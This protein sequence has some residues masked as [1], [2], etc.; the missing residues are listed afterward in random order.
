MEIYPNGRCCVFQPFDGGEFDRRFDDI[1]VPAIESAAMEPY[2]VYRDPGATIPIETLHQE[3]RSAVICVA[4]ITTRNPNVMYE[5][6]YAT[7]SGK[8]LV[9][10]SGPSAEKFP[11][12]IQ[13]HQVIRYSA[14]SISDFRRLEEGITARLKAL[15]AKQEKTGDIMAVS[16]V[17]SSDGLQPHEM[18]A[19]WLLAANTDCL[20]DTV[21]AWTLKLEMRKFGYTDAATRMSTLRLVKLGLVQSSRHYDEQFDQT[22]TLFKLTE[23]GESWVLENQSKFQLSDQDPDSR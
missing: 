15:L 20:E 17:K 10:I 23:T 18:T 21:G 19:L 22:S 6:G 11:F 7:A 13:H 14:G 2:R 1:L 16:P 3:I 8:D 9:I 5:L 12:D 4:D